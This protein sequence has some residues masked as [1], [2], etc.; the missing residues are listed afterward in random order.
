MVRKIRKHLRK[1]YPLEK[2]TPKEVLHTH[3]GNIPLN[4]A[5]TDR[6]SFSVLRNDRNKIRKSENISY[7]INIGNRWEWIVRYDDHG[8]TGLLHRHF[9]VSLKDNSEVESYA[10]IRKY[11]NKDYELT[12]ACKDIKRNYLIFRSK[13]LRN[14]NLDLY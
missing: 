6:I 11:K 7:E 5:R 3:R 4:I 10:G 2:P 1:A 9:R 13:F 12:W 14:N 8:G